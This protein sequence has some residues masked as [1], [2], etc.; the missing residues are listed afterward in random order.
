MLS[1]YGIPATTDKKGWIVQALQLLAG[2]AVDF[3]KE[4]WKLMKTIHD[5][6]SNPGNSGKPIVASSAG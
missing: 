3:T 4:P 5:Y 1:E 6:L 2:L